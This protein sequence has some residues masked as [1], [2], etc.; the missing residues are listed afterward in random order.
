MVE[1]DDNTA[2]CLSLK[3]YG[4]VGP[5]LFQQLLLT[6]GEPAGLFDRDAEE[7]A[8]MVGIDL[9]RAKKIVEARNSIGAVR[10]QVDRLAEIDIAVLSYCDRRYPTC[11][12][13]IPDPPL[14]VYLKG[15]ESLLHAGGVAIVGTTAADQAGIRSAV[16]FAG[17][18]SSRGHTVISGLAVGIDSAAHLGSLKNGGR[19]IAVLGSG[20]LNIYPEEN[21][22]LAD[23]I[24]ETGAIVSEFDIHAEAIPRRLV[25]RNRIIS[26]L[27]DLVIVIQIGEEKRGEL[28]AAGAA[29]DQGK[30]VFVFDPEERYDAETL[31]DYPVIKVKQLSEIDGI[32]RYIVR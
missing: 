29:V 7:I 17:A 12:R 28:Y 20:L 2:V 1:L 9:G 13:Q 30:P 8:S 32:L 3:E 5:K 25:S 18:V 22:P 19:T 27:A 31:L 14:A 4:Q 26:A 6:F 24:K 16:D 21:G 10:D 23:T 15:D 11:L